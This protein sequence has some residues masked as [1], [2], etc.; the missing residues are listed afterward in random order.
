MSA[1]RVLV[2]DDSS[3][4]RALIAMHLNADPDIEVAGFAR[5]AQEAREAIK[6]LNPDVITLDVEMPNMNGLDFLEKLMRLRPMPVVMVSS[7]THAGADATIRALE[8]GAVD[9]LGKSGDDDNAALSRLPD[10]V[11]NAARTKA[12]L[13]SRARQ[14]VRPSHVSPADYKAG[15]HVIAVGSSTGGV[16]A[17]IAILSRIPADCPPILVTQHMSA[18]FTPRFAH[19]LDHLCG[20]SVAE[21]RDGEALK[22]GHVY[23]APGGRTHLELLGGGELRCRLK[24]TDLVNGHRPSVDVLFQSVAK[25]VGQKAVGVILTG[26]GRDGAAGLLSMRNAGAMTIGQDEATSVVYGMPKVAFEIG[27]VQKQLPLD[28]IAAGIL[29]ATNKTSN[30]KEQS[31][32]LRKTS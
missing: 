19:R 32:A 30:N 21:A 18:C 31:Y 3:T 20:P 27:A 10:V 22:V 7:L 4:M 17:L 12:S 5:D 23:L 6:A 13:R 28:A 25:C 1:V 2:V 29:A 26:M 15:D 24:E 11:K 16:E 9:C 14:E 8:M